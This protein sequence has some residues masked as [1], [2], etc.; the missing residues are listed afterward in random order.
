[1][2]I[3]WVSPKQLASVDLVPQAIIGKPTSYFEDYLHVEFAGG[4]DDLD[5]YEG[6]VFVLNNE[7]VF[8]L[9]HYSGHPKDTT[10]VYLPRKY[11]DVNTIS[12]IVERLV[13]EL[14]I[15]RKD[16]VWQRADDPAL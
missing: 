5:A 1:M 4:D 11:Q 8:A 13:D 6:A 9:R 12:K 7:T 10:T 3:R 15:D 16:V 14:R 2:M